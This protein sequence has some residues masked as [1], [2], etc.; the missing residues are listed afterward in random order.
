MAEH[1]N[2]KYTKKYDE[3]NTIQIKL[4]LNC[5]TDADIISYLDATGN[6]QG[7]IK[8]LIREEIKR[9]PGI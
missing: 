4:K 9:K 7:T 2:Y 3:A 1:P 5:N 8:R 6:K